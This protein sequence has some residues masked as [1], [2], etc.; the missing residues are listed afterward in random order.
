M[1]APKT[2]TTFEREA[3][4]RKIEQMRL[5]GQ[6]DWE[7]AQELGI[8]TRMVYYDLKRIEKRWQAANLADLDAYKKRE[9]ARLEDLIIEHWAAWQRSQEDKETRQSEQADTEGGSRKKASIKTEGKEGNPAFLQG[10][11]RCAAEIRKLLGLDAPITYRDVT[12]LTDEE[13]VRIAT[14]KAP[15]VAPKAERKGVSDRGAGADPEEDD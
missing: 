5:R 7:I 2:K 13:L 12:E 14:G 10:V 4:L 11:E 1:A 9:L 3:R 6:R 15:A 8:S